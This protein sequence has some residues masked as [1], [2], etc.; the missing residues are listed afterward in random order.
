MCGGGSLYCLS[1][2]SG[3]F[4]S[5]PKCSLCGKAQSIGHACAGTLFDLRSPLWA[6]GRAGFACWQLIFVIVACLCQ[7]LE[8]AFPQVC[9]A[10]VGDCLVM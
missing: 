7:P 3:L 9:S 1:V 2:P 10:L 8:V 4:C 6:K 5:R